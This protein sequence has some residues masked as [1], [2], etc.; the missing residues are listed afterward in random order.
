MADP[1]ATHEIASVQ[2]RVFLDRRAIDTLADLVDGEGAENLTARLTADQPTVT[3]EEATML[4]ELGVLHSEQDAIAEGGFV[5]LTVEG[6]ALRQP[7]ALW[8][9]GDLGAGGLRDMRRLTSDPS[10]PGFPGDIPIDPGAPFPFPDGPGG[11]LGGGV[12]GGDPFPREPDPDP[13]P[14]DPDPIDPEDFW[15]PYDIPVVYPVRPLPYIPDRVDSVEVSQAQRAIEFG[16]ALNRLAGMDVAKLER[17]MTETLD[18]THY[19]RDAWASSIHTRHLEQM[20]AKQPTGSHLGGYGFVLGLQQELEPLRLTLDSPGAFRFHGRNL[21]GRDPDLQSRLQQ[22]G[23]IAAQTPNQAA[24]LAVI[25]NAYLAHA[26]DEDTANALRMNLDS[27]RVRV[28]LELIDAVREA[29]PPAD[30]LGARFERLLHRRNLE[31]FDAGEIGTEGGVA[32]YLV[33]FRDQYP[34]RAEADDPEGRHNRVVDGVALT[35]V[36]KKARKGSKPLSVVL[37]NENVHT[38]HRLVLEAILDELEGQVDAANDLLLFEATYLATTGDSAAATRALDAHAGMTAP[39]AITSVAT[40]PAGPGFTHRIVVPL[41]GIENPWPAPGN[42]RAKVSP[43]LNDWAGMLLGPPSELVWAYEGAA[44]W[45]P[46]TLADANLDPLDVVLTAERWARSSVSELDDDGNPVATST[47]GRELAQHLAAT[48]LSE[49]GAGVTADVAIRVDRAFLADQGLLD[50][51]GVAVSEIAELALRAGRTLRA[52]RPLE[53]TDLAAA[54]MQTAGAPDL[55]EAVSRLAA[56]ATVLDAAAST[57]ETL[58]TDLDEAAPDALAALDVQA[59]AVVTHANSNGAELDPRRPSLMTDESR[60]DHI[61]AMRSAASR[62]H[63]QSAAVPSV[64][65]NEDTATVTSAAAALIGRDVPFDLRFDLTPPDP[66]DEALAG[67]EKVAEPQLQTW[68]QQ[69][70]RV[71]NDATNLELATLASE[72]VIDS[73]AGTLRATQLPWSDADPW[74]G[75]ELDPALGDDGAPGIIATTSI[76]AVGPGELR[77]AAVSGLFI[78]VVNDRVPLPDHTGGVAFRYDQPSARAPQV[79]AIAV[80]PTIYDLPVR[81]SEDDEEEVGWQWE[82]LVGAID[83]MIE[84]AQLRAADPN[85]IQG[86]G[87]ALPMTLFPTS[88]SHHFYDID[89]KE[90]AFGGEFSAEG[91]SS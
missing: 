16:E 49:L 57:L 45:V 47:I 61:R 44:G 88:S 62:M 39:A 38:L 55:T 60:A 78:G 52:A 3:P 28:A 35:Q 56:G 84:D 65:G 20:R 31:M 4:G 19:R 86:V 76:C 26:H 64:L 37:P 54:G 70:A 59:V 30:V 66:L 89:L 7:G 50:D 14:P 10:M 51:R 53:P 71:L 6:F 32:Q 27:G 22:G 29:N 69:V 91:G 68:F 90:M 75:G 81:E 73:A 79:V 74:I 13:F 67:A 33:A 83:T 25:R 87:P 41:E 17:L 1:H 12:G 63:D 77:P 34:N 23:F 82:H 42:L 21:Y 85:M 9:V 58:A 15:D 36:W 43:R 72:A 24:A 46:K 11:G 80:P 48:A 40:P 5:E 18:A 2:P 8:G